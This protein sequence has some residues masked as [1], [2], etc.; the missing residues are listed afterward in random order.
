[1]RAPLLTSWPCKKKIASMQ[2]S[3]FTNKVYSSDSVVRCTGLLRLALLTLDTGSTKGGYSWPHP[4]G[5]S[6]YGSA[7]VEL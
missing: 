3:L 2:V 1:M 5:G 7:L 4:S 6:Y